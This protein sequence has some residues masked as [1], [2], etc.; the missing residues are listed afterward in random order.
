MNGKTLDIPLSYEYKNRKLSAKG[1]IDV[2]DFAMSDEL[3]ALNKACFALHEG[4]TWSDVAI[5][6]DAEFT[7]CK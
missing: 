2:F 6:I 1:V 4:K 5:G 7:S 3:A